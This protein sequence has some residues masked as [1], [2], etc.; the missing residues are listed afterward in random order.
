MPSW[1]N[2]TIFFC[3]D[4]NK[5]KE[6]EEKYTSDNGTF[7]SCS[8]I[9][10]IPQEMYIESSSDIPYIITYT[11]N[12]IKQYLHNTNNMW[13]SQPLKN[14]Y[15]LPNKV[16]IE[17]KGPDMPQY[18]Y[19]RLNREY[20]NVALLGLPYVQNIVNYNCLTA[21]DWAVEKWGTKWDIQDDGEYPYEGEPALKGFNFRSPWCPP[22]K[23]FIKLSEIEQ[24]TFFIIYDTESHQRLD[25]TIMVFKNGECCIVELPFCP[26]WFDLTPENRDSEVYRINYL[27]SL[28]LEHAFSVDNGINGVSITEDEKN[29]IIYEFCGTK[30]TDY[31]ESEDDIRIINNV[32][33]DWYKKE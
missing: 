27:N 23:A 13:L 5:L 26:D 14:K 28:A 21:R 12:K 29:H 18:M 32:S 16:E 4:D 8:K 25:P 11:L 30:K 2:G 22:Y 15:D 33:I 17:V 1:C 24:V 7:P 19:E 3:V 9:L 10:P 31:I 20:S 6:L